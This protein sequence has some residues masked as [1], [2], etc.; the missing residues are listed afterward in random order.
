[1]EEASQGVPLRSRRAIKAGRKGRWRVSHHFHTKFRPPVP[2]P[3]RKS[4]PPL[5]KKPDFSFT[6]GQ[7]S[8]T[9][10]SRC[11]QSSVTKLFG[12][13][14]SPPTSPSSGASTAVTSPKIDIW[15]SGAQMQKC[16]RA[17]GSA[18]EKARHLENGHDGETGTRVS[19][20]QVPAADHRTNIFGKR[21]GTVRAGSSW[22]VRMHVNRV[23]GLVSCGLRTR[24][25]KFCLSHCLLVSSP[26]LSP[27]PPVF[28][29]VCSL[30]GVARHVLDT[31]SCVKDPLLQFARRFLTFHSS[32]ATGIPPRDLLPIPFYPGSEVMEPVSFNKEFSCAHK[33]RLFRLKRLV[34]ACC[35]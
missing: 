8:F 12:G 33:T 24:T 20:V 19:A 15:H 6:A 30:Q 11:S 35:R 13:G 32:P 2:V 23:S 17:R 34:V 21:P 3:P 14:R 29:Q 10:S 1:M 9:S 22:F 16:Q 25:P 27:I 4:S 26:G 28:P 31:W 18:S 5:Q 7:G